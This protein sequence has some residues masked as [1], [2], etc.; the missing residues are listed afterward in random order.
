MRGRLLLRGGL[1]IDTEPT[2][3]V[4]RDTDV[5]IEHG[6]IAAVGRR[7]QVRDAEVIDATERIVL[8]GFVDTHRHVWETALRGIAVDSDPMGYLLQVIGEYSPKYR[9]EDVAAGNLAGALE[10]LDAGI[11][12]V[13]DY[14]NVQHSREHTDAA[15]DAL[16]SS[17]IRAVF[18]YGPSPLPAIPVD[19]DEMRH[20]RTR[21]SG[22]ITAAVAATGPSFLPMELTLADW[23]LADSLDLPIVCHIDRGPL[24]AHPIRLLQYK[25]LLRS[26]I[27]F[28]HGNNL[29]ASELPLIADA[30]AAVSITPVV[31]AR[32]GIGAPMAGRLRAAGVTTGLGIDVVT[33][34]ASDMFSAMHSVLALGHQTL[35]AAQV[36]QL[37]TID[38]AR[39]LGLGEKI[40]SLRPGKQADLVLL[41]TTDINLLGGLHDPVGTVVTAAHP[42]NVDT[43]LVS[44]S[45]VKEGGRLIHAAL[46]TMHTRL[47]NTLTHLKLL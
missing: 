28:V 38:G 35:T 45:F 33:A 18:G 24:T 17:G 6:R 16:E 20:V 10:C 23:A 46:A 4:H 12:T 14:S 47:Q 32:M 29:P 25:G 5:L 39:A 13:Q 37:A 3:V 44:G 26:N 42:G 30:G 43:V 7:L 41:R 1:V 36:L 21:V 40:G 34:A 31:E 27:L 19:P 2:V 11:T 22:L 9:P 15:L 8:P